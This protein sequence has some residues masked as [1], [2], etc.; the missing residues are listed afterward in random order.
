[1]VF[2]HFEELKEQ[3]KAAKKC[4]VAVACA[5]DAHTLEAVLKAAEE[6]ILDCRLLGRKEE[7]L[8]IGREM[9]YEISSESVLDCRTEE[10]AAAGAAALVREGKAD[11]LQKGLMQTATLLKAVVKKESGIRGAGL[12]SHVALLELPG[13]HKLVGITDGGMVL[14]PDLQQKK[15]IIQN[16]VTLFCG[17]GY[18]K[19]KVAVL[20]A[21]ETVNPKMPET[22]DAAELKCMAEQGALSD[23]ILEGPISM[24]LAVNPDSAKIKKYDSPVAGD[25]DILIVPDIHSGN[26]MVKAMVEFSGARMA[27]CVVGAKCPIA[28]NSR[29]AS[30]E[31]KYDSL[32]ACACM[33]GRL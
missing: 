6:G 10:E 27:G 17:F 16:A 14:Y 32:L 26:I 33:T 19:P 21:V 15:E 22:V 9:G 23:C 13:Y 30:F 3:V 11:F 2:S 4:T 24:D 8:R 7:I 20:A 29:S 25:A 12:M 1:M 18:E 28:L 5:H 31:E